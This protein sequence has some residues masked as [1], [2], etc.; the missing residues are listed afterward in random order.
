MVSSC[1]RLCSG[2]ISRW[3]LPSSVSVT[4]Y[5]CFDAIS[6]TLPSWLAAR[7]ELEVWLLTLCQVWVQQFAWRYNVY[8]FC[9]MQIHCV[10]LPPTLSPPGTIPSGE[11]GRLVLHWKMKASLLLLGS[12]RN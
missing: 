9:A 3:I 5:L 8:I 4:V 11:L 7:G 6:T 2:L 1:L 10:I 12:Y